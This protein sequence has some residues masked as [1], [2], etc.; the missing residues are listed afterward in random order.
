MIHCR[1]LSLYYSTK[2]I[3]LRVIIKSYTTSFSSVTATKGKEVL[4]T[5]KI[6][7]YR[8]SSLQKKGKTIN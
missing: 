4:F 1:S 5:S 2:S 8:P 3:I 6:N 7:Y